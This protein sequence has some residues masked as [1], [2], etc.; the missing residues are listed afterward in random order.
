M[1]DG[2]GEMTGPLAVGVSMP[3]GNRAERSSPAVPARAP[4][5]RQARSAVLAF[6]L[7]IVVIHGGFLLLLDYG[8][9]RLRDPEYGKRLEK[10]R[11]RQTEHPDRPLIL[12][13]GSSRTAMGVRPDVLAPLPPG[14]PLVMNFALAGSGP[15]MELMAFRRALADGLKPSAVILEYWPA[16]LRETDT[17]HEDGRIDVARLR[18][19]DRSIVDEF[20]RDPAQTKEKMQEHRQNPWYAHRRSILNQVA[21]RW[22]PL[23][24]RSEAMWEPIDDWGW[25]PGRAQIQEAE[26]PKA[27]AATSGYYVPLFAKYEV[28]PV[29]D[30]AY[31]QLIAECRERN[32]PVVLLYLPESAAFRAMMPPAA[33]KASEDYLVRLTKELNLPLIDARGW[34]SDD[35]LPDGFH[36]MQ[37]GAK[38]VTLRLRDE[39][40]RVLPQRTATEGRP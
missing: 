2:R 14:Q 28:S 26:R 38:T 27:I 29:A 15:I 4:R 17:Y 9:P 40:A 18:P 25:L 10:V 31:R 13:L 5:R 19:V 8:P 6:L 7:G 20:F 11:A 35:E 39:L 32:I 33:V 34:V 1:G 16:F 37:N 30:Q 23:K 24:D 36:L 22:L 12:A 3:R 21:T